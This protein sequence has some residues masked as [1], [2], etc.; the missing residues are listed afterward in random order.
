MDDKLLTIEEVADIL[1]LQYMAVWKM[2]R[3]G[4]LASVKVGNG[5]LR[6]KYRIRESDL[7]KMLNEE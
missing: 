2:V 5:K 7:N 4:K 6:L 3:S 1:R